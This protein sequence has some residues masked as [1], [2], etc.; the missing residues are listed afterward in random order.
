M[1]RVPCNNQSF[2]L[3]VPCP[4]QCWLQIALPVLTSFSL[5]SGFIDAVSLKFWKEG[6]ERSQEGLFLADTA[7]RC[8]WGF[9]YG[10][11]SPGLFVRFFRETCWEP[12]T[13]PS[14]V[15]IVW[16]SDGAF[17]A[18]SSVRPS[19]DYLAAPDCP[20]SSGS[21]RLQAGSRSSVRASASPLS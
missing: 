4:R 9:Q 19:W 12:L 5:T 16:D 3:G 13:T 17:F 10:S 20:L 21:H 2:T 6:S 18:P 7:V 14:K 8:H 1:P 15:W 11:C